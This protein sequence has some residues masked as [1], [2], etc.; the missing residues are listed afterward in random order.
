[1]KYL[2]LAM[3][4]SVALIGCSDESTPEKQTAAD[5]RAGKAVAERECK[6]CHGLDGKGVAPGIPNLA[7]QRG[8]Y[9]MAALKEYKDG[10]RVH[11][12]LRSIATDMND[13]QTRG[14]AA[15]YASLPPIPAAKGASSLPTRTARRWPRPARACHGADGNSK[16]AG[17][18]ALPAS[19]RAISSWRRRNT[20]PARANRRR[21]IQCCASWA[22]SI[23]KAWHCIS[24]RR[25]RRSAAP[26]RPAMRRRANR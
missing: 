11:A 19:S 1:M 12:A 7:G 25:R 17:T 15:F 9:I 4:L 14:V 26:R 10:K 18:P 24:P 16:T 22:G 6:G 5:I 23:L 13:D 21:W 20:S 3:F 8:R 2:L